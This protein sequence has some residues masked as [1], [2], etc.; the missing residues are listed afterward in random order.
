MPPESP[1]SLWIII[2]NWNGLDDTL[3]CLAS[4]HAMPPLPPAVQ[5]LVIDN[6]SQTDPCET[7]QRHYPQVKTMR[8]PYNAGFAGGCNVGL[9]LAVAAAAEY[10][11]LLNNDTLVEPHFLP[12]LLAYCVDNPTAGVV[13]PLIYHADQPEAIWFAGGRVR[14]SWG[15]C[16]HDQ[17]NLPTPTPTE[18]VTGC[19]M[20]IARPVLERVGLL[21]EAFFAY[22][23]D[24]D[25]CLRARRAG[26]V[27]TY[28]PQSVI[29]H[30][31]SAGT[32]P[33]QGHTS[34]LKHYLVARNRL[35][36]VKKHGRRS[37][38]AFFVL[39]INPIIT[40]FFLLA[41]LARRRWHKLAALLWGMRDGL[42]YQPQ[43]PKIVPL[44]D[45]LRGED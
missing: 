18:Y 13:A 2:L 37:A 33:L 27:P 42:R 5:I 14:L 22:Y 25:F 38:I 45:F 3:A 11:L 36:L 6:H 43:N 9:R 34:P 39:I 10:V 35:M 15:H 28:V 12:P 1:P 29:W 20:L 30:K 32:R 31:V 16:A 8:L 24:V 4:L 21:D 19:C 7:I 41:F 17:H 23:E 26:F 40:V 44:P